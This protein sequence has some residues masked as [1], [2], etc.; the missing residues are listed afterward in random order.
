MA[1]SDLLVWVD[2]E[3]T[4]LDLDRERI[5]EI[6]TLLT[7]GNLNIVAEGPDLVVHQSDELLDGMDAWNST[8]HRKSGLFDRVRASNITETQAEELT[9]AFVTE[10]CEPQTAPLSGNSIYYDRRFL[11]KYMPR[12]E[13]FVHYRNIDVSTIKELVRRW[14]P[15]VSEGAPPKGETHRAMDDIRESIEELR[16]YRAKV[17]DGL[18]TR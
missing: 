14:Y 16:Y 17:F 13:R 2:L 18:T 6:S 8:Q 1:K 9:L 12:L 5:I 7:D 4:G 15:A 10:H 3:M 11:Q